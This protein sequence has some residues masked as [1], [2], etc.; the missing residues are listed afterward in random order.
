MPSTFDAVSGPTPPRHRGSRGSASGFTLIEL[1]VVVSILAILASLLLPALSSAKAKGRRAVCLSNLRQIGTA[2]RVYAD[3]HEGHIPF[4]PTAPP[5]TSPASF[6]PS[7]GAPTSLMSLRDGQPVGLGLLLENALAGQPK[8][9]FCPGNDQ[10]VDTAREL[11]KVRI[12]QAQSSYYYRHGGNTRLFDPVG[13]PFR[14][15]HLQ[16]DA[17]G[18]NRHGHA[19]RALVMDTQF[20]C[21]PD[22][23]S[24]NVRPRTH[25]SRRDQ[26]ILFADGSVRSRPN[27]EER[28]TVDL[29]DASELR[30]AFDKILS[31]FERADIEP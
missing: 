8:V 15:E 9:V 24:F 30:L 6:Y 2:I 10:P 7:T 29:S 25:H 20:L 22:L 23:E 18:E 17:L 5:F 26:G 1:L 28:F 14:P 21:P 12:S 3:D 11:S 13:A 4:G 16:L 19:I 31:A 27:K